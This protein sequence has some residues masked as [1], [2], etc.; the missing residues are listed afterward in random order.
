MS[1]SQISAITEAVNSLAISTSSSTTGGHASDGP[2]RFVGVKRR[3][4]QGG[5]VGPGV[6]ELED[7]NIFLEGLGI[8][9]AETL[10]AARL[11]VML[12]RA[13]SHTLT[14]LHQRYQR[15][16]REYEAVLDIGTSSGSTSDD[17]DDASDEVG[18]QGI[19]LCR[20]VASLIADVGAETEIFG[21]HLLP[22]RR[23]PSAQVRQSVLFG[24]VRERPDKPFTLPGGK[25][26][27]QDDGG[28]DRDRI[29]RNIDMTVRH[30]RGYKSRTVINAIERELQEEGVV[31][32]CGAY[33]E[34]D[35]HISSA[36]LESG[37]MPK[38]AQAFYYTCTC[39][40]AGLTWLPLGHGDAAPWVWRVVLHALEHNKIQ[41][42]IQHHEF[43]ARMLARQE[44]R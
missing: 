10:G 13:M 17:D 5:G 2:S 40:P 6:W 22:I 7:M 31:C 1:E 37:D 33:R 29:S 41:L 24:M 12:T 15:M 8:G 27:E 28:L 42:A 32:A 21:V 18:P 36:L 43:T 35:V 19:Q 3:R 20:H 34:R 4:T 39:I 38:F 25:I 30:A 16:L 26:E 23:M 14:N 44:A 9:D 11:R